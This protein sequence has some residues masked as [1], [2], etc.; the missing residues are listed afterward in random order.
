MFADSGTNSSG[1]IYLGRKSETAV[2]RSSVCVR[3]LSSLRPKE[4]VRR[5]FQKEF[6]DGSLSREDHFFN[7]ADG[8]ETFFAC[9]FMRNTQCVARSFHL[10]WFCLRRF[11]RS[12]CRAFSSGCGLPRS[13]GA[14]AERLAE[15]L[16]AWS[17]GRTSVGPA[18]A[19]VGV[20][21]LEENL[22]T[23][24]RTGERK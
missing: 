14:T 15:R 6:G 19:R 18:E 5:N 1:Q 17:C 12:L 4:P 16:G 2:Q 9:D 13:L 23:R 22:V 3:R 7:L 8:A 11:F 24:S 20:E 21:A 10:E